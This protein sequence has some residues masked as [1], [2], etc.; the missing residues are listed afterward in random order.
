M[1]FASNLRKGFKNSIYKF[2]DFLKFTG[3][4]KKSIGIFIRSYH[5][6]A[7]RDLMIIVLFAP[8]YYCD[9]AMIF[10]FTIVFSLFHLFNGC[11]LTIIEQELCEDEFSMLDPALEICRMEINNKNRIF[12]SYISGYFYLFSICLIYYFRFLYNK[13]TSTIGGDSIPVI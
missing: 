12:I 2:V 4:S 6:V 3:L 5:I 8:K 1:S 10:F 7:V 11:F 9:I 13:T